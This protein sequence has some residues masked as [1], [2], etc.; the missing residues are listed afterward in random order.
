MYMRTIIAAAAFVAMVASAALP[1]GAAPNVEARDTPYVPGL[2]QDCVNACDEKGTS[3]M[4]CYGS[5]RACNYYTSD[6][7]SCAKKEGLEALCIPPSR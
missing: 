4:L 1:Q 2:S 6:V 5:C 7:G 3:N